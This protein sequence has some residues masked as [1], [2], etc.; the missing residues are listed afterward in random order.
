[1][2]VETIFLIHSWY[3]LDVE[4]QLS[5]LFCTILYKGLEH[6]QILVSVGGLEPIPRGQK[7]YESFD[8]RGVATSDPQVVYSCLQLFIVSWMLMDLV[9]TLNPFTLV[10]IF[11]V[12]K[13]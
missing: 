12:F 5:A 8:S 9:L 7:L 13:F 6:P 10:S 11:L 1:M 2:V 3:F 4:D